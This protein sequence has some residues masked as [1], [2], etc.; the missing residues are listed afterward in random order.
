LLQLKTDHSEQEC[1]VTLSDG[2]KVK[3][4]ADTPEFMPI[5][6]RTAIKEQDQNLESKGKI[7]GGGLAA[8]ASK[9]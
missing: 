3:L 2:P 1:S 5:R 4:K 9:F 7:G 6:L 8:H